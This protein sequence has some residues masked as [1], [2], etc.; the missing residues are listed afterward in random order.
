MSK[1]KD[2]IPLHIKILGWYGIVF[3][4]MYLVYSVVSVIL[5]ILDRSYADI[6]NN[7]VIGL[8]GIP[9]MVCSIGFKNIQRWGWIG[10]AVILLIVA[11][12]SFISMVDAYS[13]TVGI[14][15]TVVL[16][17]LFIPSVRKQYFP[18]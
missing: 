13:V 1:E 17:Q 18:A 2:Q 12:W 6:G 7:I 5:A 9:I 3:G 15:S 10:Y 14:I 4:L 11:A 16:L 8:Y